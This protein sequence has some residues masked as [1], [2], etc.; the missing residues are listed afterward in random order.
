MFGGSALAAGLGDGN[1]LIGYS[2]SFLSGEAYAMNTAMLWAFQMMFAGTAPATMVAAVV[3]LAII[4]G[5]EASELSITVDEHSGALRNHIR[6]QTRGNQG[7]KWLHGL[8]GF[9]QGQRNLVDG[10]FRFMN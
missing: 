7:L 5:G 3:S 2:G 9:V 8:L 1:F 6:I 4:R 10:E